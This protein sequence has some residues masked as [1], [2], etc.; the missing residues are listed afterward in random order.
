MILNSSLTQERR[1][2]HH[3]DDGSADPDADGE[4]GGVDAHHPQRRDQPR[5][6][7]RH[8]SGKSI[9]DKVLGSFKLQ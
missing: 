4:D 5:L 6:G 2:T 1:S 9:Y 3:E 7:H 8:Y